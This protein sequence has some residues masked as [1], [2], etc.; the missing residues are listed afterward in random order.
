M[1]FNTR[2]SVEKYSRLLTLQRY[3]HSFV[4]MFSFFVCDTTKYHLLWPLEKDVIL[5]SPLWFFFHEGVCVFRM[6]LC[7]RPVWHKWGKRNTIWQCPIVLKHLN[8]ISKFTWKHTCQRSSL[9]GNHTHTVLAIPPC[10]EFSNSLWK[11]F[12]ID[13]E[14]CLL[15]LHFRYFFESRFLWK[16]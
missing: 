3:I 14:S 15:L 2:R 13:V 1:H 7:F 9:A 4:V 6:K 5:I 11:V 12:V 16:R 10:I 8:S